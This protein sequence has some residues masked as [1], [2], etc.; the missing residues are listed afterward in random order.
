MA[1]GALMAA[2]AVSTGGL[3][4]LF[5]K[6][7]RSKKSA[8]KDFGLKNTTEK[9]KSSWLQRRARGKFRE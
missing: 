4:S 1:S 9:E 3:T 8:A 5:M 7:L 2:S 6:L